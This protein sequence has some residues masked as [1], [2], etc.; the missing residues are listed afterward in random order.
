MVWNNRLS[1][2]WDPLCELWP[3]EPQSTLLQK[4]SLH[5]QGLSPLGQVSQS[6]LPPPL[7]PLL[8]LA[9]CN[10][11]FPHP[12]PILF[13][14]LLKLPVSAWMSKSLRPHSPGL[15]AGPGNP[16]TSSGLSSVFRRARA[17]SGPTTQQEN[18]WYLYFWVWLICLVDAV[19]AS[20][21]YNDVETFGKHSGVVGNMAGLSVACREV[22]YWLL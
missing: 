18:V 22:S 14:A 7:L 5:S 16:Q 4:T 20:V 9:R 6:S 17:H 13:S 10:P 12:H 3:T 19:Q 2:H 21:W 15:I 11:W 1:L 8:P